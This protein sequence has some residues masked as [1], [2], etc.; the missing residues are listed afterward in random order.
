MPPAQLLRQGLRARLGEHH[1]L[2]N[3]G[4]R[5]P[6]SVKTTAAPTRLEPAP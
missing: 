4:D 2:L 5:L 1:L 3:A 6:D